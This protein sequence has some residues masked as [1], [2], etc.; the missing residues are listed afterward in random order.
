[1]I[2]HGVGIESELQSKIFD[3]FV[4]S[5]QRLDRSRGGL[6]VGLSLARNIVEL[7]GG[8]IAVQSDGPGKG[9]V[10][11]GC[12]SPGAGRSSTFA[13]AARASDSDARRTARLTLMMSD[14]RSS[15]VRT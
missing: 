2:D 5:E 10:R 14:V 7:H 8:T 15:W 4:Q 3:L 13:G 11:S 9:S 6:G 1:M 12:S